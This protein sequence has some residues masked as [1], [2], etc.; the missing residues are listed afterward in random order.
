MKY[1]SVRRED[2]RVI[3]VAEADSLRKLESLVMKIVEEEYCG[4]DSRLR[5]SMNPRVEKFEPVQVSVEVFNDED[6]WV[7]IEVTV[8][9]TQIYS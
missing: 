4:L 3:G 8:E 7:E 2:N 9:E 5:E 1:Y 6:E